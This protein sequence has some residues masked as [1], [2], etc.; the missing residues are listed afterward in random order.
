VTAVDVGAL[1]RN[2]ATCWR[3][4][5][6]TLDV[7]R[8]LALLYAE[9][10]PQPLRRREWVIGFRYPAPV[11][12]IRL[13]LRA[14]SGADAFIHSEVFEHRY[15]HLPSDRSPATIL[16]LGANIG[17]SAIYL[18]RRF[19]QAEVACVEPIPTN[20]DVLRRNLA[21]NGVKARIFPAAVDSAEGFAMMQLAGRDYGHRIVP[22]GER[23]PQPE[24]RVPVV[25]VPAIMRQLGWDRI[26]LAKID[27]EGQERSLFG[28]NCDWLNS[29]DSIVI[30]C[31]DDFGRPELD[32]LADR[33]GFRV[34][35]LPSA[36]WY[37]D[38][39]R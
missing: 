18:S 35:K 6:G 9:R 17:L 15:Y 7:A 8:R 19:P 2:V 12:N 16:D 11:G 32:A 24:L 5:A 13:V 29:V 23:G 28:A 34:E 25:S 4:R 22:P 1:A 39:I 14:N 33:F 26:G 38:R 31:H 21:M 10:C 37:L 27:I 30:E 3:H 20:L 36:M